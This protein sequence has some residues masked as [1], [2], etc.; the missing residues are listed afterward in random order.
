MPTPTPA[1]RQPRI[2]YGWYIVLGSVIVNF[3]LS[4]VYFQG[5]QVFFLPIVREFGWSRA[6]TSGAFSLRQMES[7]LLAPVVGLLVD[8]WGPRAVIILGVIISG[9]GLV[10]LSRVNSLWMFYLAFLLTSL[11]TSGVSHG[12]SWP[13]AVAA[14][15]RRLRGRAMGIATLGPVVGGPFVVTVAFLEGW[16][17]WRTSLLVLGVGLWVIGIPAGMLARTSPERYGYRPDGDRPRPGETEAEERRRNDR[18]WGFTARQAVRSRTFWLIALLF[19]IQGLGTSGLMVHLIPLL[20]DRQFSAEQAASIVGAVFLLSGI[21]RIGAGLFVDLL[22]QRLII[23]SL[24]GLQIGALLVLTLAGGHNWW[25]VV[26]FVT[27]FGPGFG[28][29]VPLRPLLIMQRFGPRA[30][31][32]IN[33]LTQSA[34]VGT[35]VIGPILYGRIFDVTGA[36]DL[37]LYIS[38]AGVAASIPFALWL[39]KRQELMPT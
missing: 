36:Y 8:R 34:A 35:G 4:V 38:M 37:A 33:G 27:L 17:G 16:L 19:G 1:R 21:G 32:A 28:G 24:L 10:L 6:T 12:V 30:F 7:G 18:G 9:A 3:Y 29:T 15:F 5:F 20:E 11:G 31:G 26:L 22:D 14:W 23:L 25:L 39:G 13:A 2:F